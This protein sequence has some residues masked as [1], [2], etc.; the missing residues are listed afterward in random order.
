MSFVNTNKAGKNICIEEHG[1]IR[2]NFNPELA[3][4]GFRTILNCFQQVN[5]IRARDPIENQHLVSGQLKKTM[6]LMSC[7]L[8]PTM[9]SRDTGQQIPCFDRCQLIIT[10]MSNIKEVHGKP[11]LHV[12][13]NLL[14]WSMAA[15][16]RDSTVVAVVRTHP[17]A[18]PLPMITMR[19][20]IHGF[21]FPYMVMGLRLMAL[22]AA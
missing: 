16:L 2:I 17:R 7:R 6:T 14:F 1:I 21:C 19:K 13:I 5:L 15:M 11:R 10:W 20:S 9:W 22:R 3:L 8:E 18:I 12:S 4:A